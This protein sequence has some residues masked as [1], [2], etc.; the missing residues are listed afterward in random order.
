[1]SEKSGK[2]S[3]G[4][5]NFFKLLS[6]GGTGLLLSPVIPSAAQAAENQNPVKPATNIQDAMKHPRTAASMPG[7]LPGKVVRVDHSGCI[8]EHVIQQKAVDEMLRSLM[9][10]LTGETSV[11]KAWLKFVTPEDVIGLKVNPV[12]GKLLTTSHELV[13]AVIAQL[14]EAGIP[15]KNLVIWDRR[16]MELHETGYL[17]E[18]YPGITIAGTEQKDASGSFYDSN[19][20][21]YGENMIDKEWFYWA[22]VEGSYDAYTM[23]YM[24]NGGKHSYFSKICTKQVTKIINLPILKNAGSS[25][26]LCMKNLA[27]GAV[28]NTGRLHEKLWHDTVAEVC[29]FPPIRDKVVLNIVDGL[30]GCYNGGPAANPQFICPYHLLLGGTDAVAV[31]RI[32]LNIVTQKRIEMKLQKEESPTASLFLK[33]AQELGLGIGEHDKIDLKHV[34]LA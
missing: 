33:R 10:N 9:L 29:A 3:T 22:D 20:K 32:G 2:K 12:A 16:E 15:R 1:M 34:T 4:R 24:V 30:I 23:P 26:T 19:G 27:F 28:S 18:N 7:L 14:T 11:D 13:K 5:R 21:L 25:V 8:Q 17:P 6:A 31:D